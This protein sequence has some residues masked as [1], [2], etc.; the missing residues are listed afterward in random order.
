MPPLLET[1]RLFL[2]PFTVDDYEAAY[3]ALESDPDVWRYDPGY[4]RSYARRSLIIERYALLNDEGGCGVLAAVRKDNG[5]LIGYMGLQHYLLPQSPHSTAEVELFYKLG[6]AH[7][8]HGFALEG[9]LR[10][11]AFAFVELRLN[12][13]VTVT[14]GENGR[15]LCLLKRLGMRIEPAP[16][17]WSN[18]VL[19]IRE[20]ESGERE[21]IGS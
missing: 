7:W 18:Y 13:I 14:H 9:C 10:L 2:R 8:G 4:Q 1:E 11:L 16:S 15:S 5:Q 6:R 17:V 20:N 3:A 12:R 21:T 19:G